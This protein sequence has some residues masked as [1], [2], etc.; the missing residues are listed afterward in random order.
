MN[1]I[2]DL[3]LREI[4]KRVGS[5]ELSAEDVVRAYVQ[6]IEQRESQIRAWKFFD[7]DAAIT[8]ARILDSRFGTPAQ[9]AGIPIG[10]KD[11]FDTFDMPTCYGSPIYAHHR[12]SVDAALVAKARTLGAIVMGKTVTTEF[13][14]FKPGDTRNPR[15]P[16][17][18]HPHTPGGSSSGSAAAVAAG[19]V[20]VAF[21]TQTAG[22][23]IRPA[24][25]CGVVGYKPTFG[26]LSLSGAKALSQ[27]LDTAGVI[28][29][30]VD[31]AA[32]I[33]GLLSNQTFN[34]DADHAFRFA[35]CQTP[36]WHLTEPA[37]RDAINSSSH[38]LASVGLAASEVCL[39]AG[40]GDLA[41]AHVQIMTYEAAAS[42]V[43]ECRT[44]PSGLSAPFRQILES[45]A[46]LGGAGY[47]K[48][49]QLAEKGRKLIDSLFD[50]YDILISPSATGEAPA[51]LDAT[52]DPI[53]GRIWT[54]LG[55]PCVHVPTGY[56][57]NG[58]PV[59]V[60]LIGARWHDEIV[61]SAATRL[62][63]LVGALSTCGTE[64]GK[65]VETRMPQ[66]T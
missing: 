9:L 58:L 31:D 35:I 4:A 33:V 61:L 39:P 20:P 49:Q 44:Q 32:Y 45:G 23:V 66:K 2:T 27:S 59:G 15:S 25:Y 60:T 38:L 17:I 7:A 24:A 3:G 41:T 34:V 50:E 47:A 22:S 40:C 8:Q 12:P 64:A 51:G 42:Y 37:S 6:V 1:E 13:A 16:D 65:M 28:S 11:L 53:F 14:T 5:R 18:D 56:G 62:A 48:A 36:H 63:S 55:Y 54:M 21:G 43:P 46:K 10:V 52:G 29:R 26:T 57:P 19:M 30:T